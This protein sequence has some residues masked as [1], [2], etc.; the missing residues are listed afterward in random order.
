MVSHR[1]SEINLALCIRTNQG[2]T[3]IR[4]GWG[5]IEGRGSRVMWLWLSGSLC[6]EAAARSTLSSSAIC[7]LLLRV[8]QAN[9]FTLLLYALCLGN[10]TL[11]KCLLT[12]WVRKQCSGCRLSNRVVCINFVWTSCLKVLP[13]LLFSHVV[14]ET[15]FRSFLGHA[16][17]VLYHW[18]AH[19]G[20]KYLWSFFLSLYF[21]LV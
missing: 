21:I 16:G 6:L 15:E 10:I 9:V 20:W 11:N 5:H 7:C 1:L 19:P 4:E 14:L 17:G 2:V 12:E 3:K 18:A 13:V 8:K